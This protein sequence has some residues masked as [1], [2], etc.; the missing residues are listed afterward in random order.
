[1]NQYV[2]PYNRRGTLFGD[3]EIVALKKLLLESDKTL[4]GGEQRE[5]FEA[6]FAAYV[7]AKFAVSVTSCTVALE[8]ATYLLDL[9]P[10]NVVIVTPQTYWASINPLLDID[11]NVRF[12]DIDS[13]SLNL[14]PARLADL[15]CANTRAIYVT[16]YGGLMANMDPILSIAE[17][18]GLFVIEDCAHA[19]GSEYKGHRPGALGDIGCF[20]FQSMKNMSTLGEGGMITLKEPRWLDV[21]R[22]LRE[23]E[24]D[25]EFVPR[26]SSV[27]GPYRKNE[28]LDRHEKNAFTH[29]CSTIRRHGTNA[30]M[31]EPAALIGRIQLEKLPNLIEKRRSIASRLNEALSR[32]PGLRIQHEPEGFFHSYHLYTFFVEPD[33]G[34]DHE[35]LITLIDATGVEIQMRYFPLHLLSEWRLRGG[36]PGLC[37]IAEKVWFEQ[38]VNLPIYPSLTED[39]VD[40][41]IKTVEWAV[42]KAR[43]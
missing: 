3:E 5:A 4:S 16:H 6:E 11:V 18:Y 41:M 32:V 22:R 26:T 20:S 42:G 37:P 25:A 43:L 40:F 34:I 7:G 8:L 12:C 14:D 23:G 21:L 39:Q 29:D 36:S 33:S 1:M 38:Q 2:V 31:S 24:P 35:A 13:N 15:I 27:I 30:I 28:S 19:H 17:R 10:G 9:Q